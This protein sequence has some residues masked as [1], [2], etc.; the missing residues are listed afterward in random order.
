MGSL[1]YAVF[2]VNKVLS[3][4]NIKT[5]FSPYSHLQ[6]LIRASKK[7]IAISNAAMAFKLLVN[8]IVSTVT[9]HMCVGI[10]KPKTNLINVYFSF[11]IC[12]PYVVTHTSILKEV[13]WLSWKI[14]LFRFFFPLT[15]VQ[16]EH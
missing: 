8:Y 14:L 16:T 6:L 3:L 2:I 7:Q 4:F 13:Q 1:T 5:S 10:V 12:N 15:A 9:N 11:R